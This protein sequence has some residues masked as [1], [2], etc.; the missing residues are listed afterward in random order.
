M[1]YETAEMAEA[2]LVSITAMT[3]LNCLLCTA[4]NNQI[5]SNC[6]KVIITV[7]FEFCYCCRQ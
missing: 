4:F 1:E 2:A 5:N 6:S 7:V 3:V